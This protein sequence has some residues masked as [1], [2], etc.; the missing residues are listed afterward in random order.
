MTVAELIEKL[1]EMPQDLPVC[2]D[3][4]ADHWTLARRVA[5]VEDMALVDRTKPRE[6][7]FVAI[8]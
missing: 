5:I 4:T 7:E 6:C 8:C 3:Q 2:T 1:K